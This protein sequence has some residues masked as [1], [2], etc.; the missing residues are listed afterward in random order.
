METTIPKSKTKAIRLSTGNFKGSNYLQI[1]ELWKTD[2][3]EED[4]E[5]KFSKKNVTIN[6][7]NIKEFI[8]FIKDNG[9]E[10]IE[11]VCADD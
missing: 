7:N 3:A 11:T 8:D 9:D 6:K 10:I 2:A 5:W 4:E 1:M